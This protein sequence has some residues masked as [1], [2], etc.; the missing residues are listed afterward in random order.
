MAVPKWP[1]WRFGPN[2]E[3]EIFKAEEE[4]PEG[5]TDTFVPVGKKST[6][7]VAPAEPSADN[8]L[9]SVEVRVDA[10]ID[11]NSHEELVVILETMNEERGEE[12]QIEFL[13]SWPKKKLAETIVENE[14]SDEEDA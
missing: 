10:L 5:W 9:A 14:A 4:V 6:K 11:E 13:K 7:P 3:Q 12:D 1:G 8:S 2:G